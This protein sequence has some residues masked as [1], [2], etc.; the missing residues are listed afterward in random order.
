MQRLELVNIFKDYKHDVKT[1]HLYLSLLFSYE[2]SLTVAVILKGQICV[3]MNQTHDFD[4]SVFIL[5]SRDE[6]SLL[7]DTQMNYPF[8]MGKR[9]LL[10][11]DNTVIYA[12]VL[13]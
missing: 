13:R 10:S 4:F 5:W 12:I 6:G 7:C 2:S 8:I 3:I 11:R 9:A 1:T